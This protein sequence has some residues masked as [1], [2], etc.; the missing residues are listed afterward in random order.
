MATLI[1]PTSALANHSWGNYHW[2]RSANPFTL[3]LGNNL[4]SNWQTHLGQASSDWNSSTILDTTIV[5]GQGGKSCK[6]ATGRIEVCNKTYGKNGWLGL[7]QIWLSGTHITKAVTKVNDT[8]FNTPTY[9]T[10][11]WRQLVMCQELGHDFGLD[12]QDENFDNAPL[13]TC[14]DYTSDPAPNQHPNSHD[15][16][17]LETIYAHL[18]TFTTIGQSLTLVGRNPEADPGDDASSWG[19]LVR[20]SGRAAIYEKDLGN[21]HKLLTHVFYAD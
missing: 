14:M 12:H 19:Q 2:A 6:A 15:Y 9:N 16:A 3:Q 7:A 13:G 17:Q 20:S 10:S 1:F 5:A 18:D 8:Y 4:T 21:G 11:A